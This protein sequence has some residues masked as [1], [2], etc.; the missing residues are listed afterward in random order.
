MLIVVVVTRDTRILRIQYQFTRT[1]CVGVGKEV[2]MKRV[3][4]IMTE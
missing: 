3:S 1:Q 4:Q 2:K